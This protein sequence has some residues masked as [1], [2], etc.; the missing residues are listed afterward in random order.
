MVAE[1]YGAVMGLQF[2]KCV[3]K[4]AFSSWIVFC[5]LFVKDCNKKFIFMVMLITMCVKLGI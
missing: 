2:V 4:I 5:V 1:D 3:S